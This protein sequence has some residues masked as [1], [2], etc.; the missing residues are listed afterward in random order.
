MINFRILAFVLPMAGALALAGP[1]HAAQSFSYKTSYRNV[2]KDPD[3]V[4]S[5]NELSPLSN[6][7]VTIHEYQLRTPQGDFL[8]SQIWNS[9]CSAA[10][11]PTRLIKIDAEGRRVVLVDDMMHQIIPPDDRRFS[12]LS[13]SKEQGAFA[14]RPFSLTDDGKTLVNGDFKFPF[15]GSKQ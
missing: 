2:A 12:S 15:E 11:C 6:G 4:W 1:S 8:I 13:T 5:D 3:H 14:Q 9:D 7:A 10:T